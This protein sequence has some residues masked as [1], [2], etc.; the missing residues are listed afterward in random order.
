MVSKDR[1]MAC[2]FVWCYMQSQAITEAERVKTEE[3]EVKEEDEEDVCYY[4]TREK[5]GGNVWCPPSVHK[6]RLHYW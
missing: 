5:R 2:D 3:V 6:L 4:L 1:L